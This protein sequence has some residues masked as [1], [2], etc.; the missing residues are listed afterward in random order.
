LS[1]PRRYGQGGAGIG[2]ARWG[3]L[4]SYRDRGVP[5]WYLQAEE[6]D[7]VVDLIYAVE[8]NRMERL[9]WAA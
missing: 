2:L 6:T 8:D 5:L 3:L 7:A 1:A 9:E 4:F